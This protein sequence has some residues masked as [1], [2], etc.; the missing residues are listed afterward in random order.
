MRKSS[1]QL[2]K[3]LVYTSTSS[4]TS[5]FEK[6]VGFVRIMSDGLDR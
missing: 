5:Y 3:I 6:F 4:M 1:K 2:L